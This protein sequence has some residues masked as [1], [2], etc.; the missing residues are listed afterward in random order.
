[1]RL[2]RHAVAALALIAGIGCLWISI[3]Y[4][5]LAADQLPPWLPGHKAHSNPEHGH[6]HKRHGLTAFVAGGVLLG[7]A[8]SLERRAGGRGR[9]SD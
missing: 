9:T 5:A 7:V 8:W 4:W 2:V 3:T 6:H 1:V